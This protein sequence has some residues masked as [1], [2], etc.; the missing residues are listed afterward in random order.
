M[1]IK[2]LLLKNFSFSSY[3]VWILFRFISSFTFFNQTTINNWLYIS[4]SNN[5]HSLF[6]YLLNTFTYNGMVRW[7]KFRL[8]NFFDFWNRLLINY[9]RINLLY[10]NGWMFSFSLSTYSRT[11]IINYKKKYSVRQLEKVLGRFLFLLEYCEKCGWS[12]VRFTVSFKFQCDST[13]CEY[14]FENVSGINK[15]QNW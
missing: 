6:T 9:H 1:K 11:F 12:F 2:I 3:L 14:L 10:I 4:K 8:K 7:N 13:I 5:I 15:K